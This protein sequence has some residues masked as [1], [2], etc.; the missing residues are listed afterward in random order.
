[1]RSINN[2]LH[3]SEACALQE[4]RSAPA[5]QPS[6]ELETLLT[7]SEVAQVLRQSPTTVTRHID[8]GTLVALKIGRSVR[9]KK[10]EVQ[11]F[12]DAQQVKQKATA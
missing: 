10:S 11:R 5:A 1:M 12:I 6:A 9:V 2:I 3:L 8:S 4:R 7:T